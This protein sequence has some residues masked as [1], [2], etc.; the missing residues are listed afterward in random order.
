VPVVTEEPVP[1]PETGEPSYLVAAETG[2]AVLAQASP[3]AAAWWR[4]YMPDLRGKAFR[5]PA[6]ACKRVQ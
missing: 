6:S 2:L 5:F 1:H 3:E 4:E